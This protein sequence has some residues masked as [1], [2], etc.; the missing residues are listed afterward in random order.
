MKEYCSERK[1]FSVIN[2]NVQ[3]KDPMTHCVHWTEPFVLVTGHIQ[4]CCALNEANTR[5]WQKEYAFANLFKADFRDWWKSSKRKEFQKNIREDKINEICR[6]CHIY[7]HPDS[8]RVEVRPAEAE[9]VPH[10]AAREDA[11]H[12]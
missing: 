11:A 7:P 10:A 4:A 6:Y 12:G 3:Q 9:A 1:V 2:M 8:Y 5:D